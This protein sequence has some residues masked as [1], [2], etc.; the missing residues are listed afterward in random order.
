MRVDG[1]F[2]GVTLGYL[3]HF[4]PRWFAKLTGNYALP[5]AALLL[6]PVIFFE[7]QDHR[8]QRFGLTGIALGFIFIVAWAVVRTPESKMGQRVAAGFASIGLYSY[9]IYLWH[10]AIADAFISHPPSTFLKFWSYILCCIVG[11]MAMAYLV[12]IPYLRL[13]DRLFP[14][15]TID[16]AVASAQY[17]S[18]ALRPKTLP[19]VQS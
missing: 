4:K 9:S 3:N 5:I 1:L 7:Q 2:G 6:S 14:A 16:N 10:T 17:T 15:G 11:G 18:V 19:D 13:R 8:I 12:E